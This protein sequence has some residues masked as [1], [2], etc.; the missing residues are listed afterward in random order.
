MFS[1]GDKFIR[2]TK[3][4]S[5]IIGEVKLFHYS[6]NVDLTNKVKY[7]KYYIITTKG[8]LLEL[9]GSDGKIYKIEKEYSEKDIEAAMERI[10]KIKNLK[11]V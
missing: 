11:N 2:F 8:I 10:N 6:L 5:V 3:Y 7:K 9:D 1:E 4:G